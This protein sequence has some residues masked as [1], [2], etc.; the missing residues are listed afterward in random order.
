MAEFVGAALRVGE[1]RVNGGGVRWMGLR[2][3]CWRQRGRSRRSVD[4]RTNGEVEREISHVVGTLLS[5]GC[6]CFREGWPDLGVIWHV[7]PSPLYCAPISGSLLNV[8][9]V[10]T[11]LYA[12]IC[13]YVH[14]SS[15]VLL[16]IFVCRYMV[17]STPS[18]TGT[19]AM[20]A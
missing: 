3:S 16:S 13:T 2:G 1:L 4:G 11:C 9:K 6:S 20:S 14:I 12:Y 7:N 15:T 10:H 17:G 18:P 19:A 5:R 8:H